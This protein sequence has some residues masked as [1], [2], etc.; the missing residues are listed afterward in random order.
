MGLVWKAA[1]EPA[2]G[3]ESSSGKLTFE[4]IM[5][6]KEANPVTI[7]REL[8]SVL[9]IDPQIISGAVRFKGTRVPV[10]ALIDTLDDGDGLAEFLDGYPGVT[11]EQAEA[12]LFA[13]S[14]P[15]RGASLVLNRAD[16]AHSARPQ[17]QPALRAPSP[18]A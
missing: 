8:Q 7:P 11:R 12:V 10:Q 2:F 16:N 13:G 6:G 1:R 14:K 9:D 4:A 5:V 17:R 15:R 3:D 18:R